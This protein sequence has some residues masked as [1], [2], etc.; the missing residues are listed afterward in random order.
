[1]G[2]EKSKNHLLHHL[3]FTLQLNVV[4]PL[5][6]G[7]TKTEE[8]GPKRTELEAL[9][10]SDG[11]FMIIPGSSIRGVLSQHLYEVL[12]ILIE[13][14]DNIEELIA[15]DFGYISGYTTKESSR[16][17]N[18]WI[19]DIQ[20]PIK[21]KV[22][23]RMTPIDRVMHTAMPLT[24]DSIDENTTFDLRISIENASLIQLGF[25]ALFFRDLK[26]KRIQ[27][28]GGKS[29][30]FGV[31]ELVKFDSKIRNYSRSKEVLVTRDNHFLPFSA[32]WSTQQ[33]GLI[34]EYITDCMDD[35]FEWARSARTEIAQWIERRM[36]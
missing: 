21:Q 35:F 14:E 18:M 31:V 26:N 34:T 2:Q 3:D 13:N 33:H 6:I 25:L 20:I 28:G 16:K 22:V 8:D 30:G 29:R 32:K 12:S 10:S 17:G 11:K 9:Q 36:A 27:I 5:H 24:V 4:S 23:K 1:M 15:N 19:G 7:I